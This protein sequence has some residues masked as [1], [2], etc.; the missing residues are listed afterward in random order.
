VENCVSFDKTLQHHCETPSLLLFSIFKTGFKSSCSENVVTNSTSTRPK[1]DYVLE[2]EIETL[3]QKFRYFLQ[4]AIVIWPNVAAAMPNTLTPPFCNLINVPVLR[5]ALLI[6]HQQEGNFVIL[7]RETEE[8]WNKFRHFLKMV[9]V[10]CLN[11]AAPLP[12]TLFSFSWY[13]LLV[14]KVPALRM[15]LWI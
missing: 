11:A 8:L 3:T 14:L 7:V 4:I 13:S 6:Q 10:I 15:T 9:F 1:L 2:R 12:N 5:M